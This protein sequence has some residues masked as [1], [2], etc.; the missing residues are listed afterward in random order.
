[1]KKSVW[2]GTAAT[3][4]SLLRSAVLLTFHDVLIGEHGGALGGG[5]AEVGEAHGGGQ[6]E[7]DGEPDQ[8]ARDEPPHA[9]AATAQCS[10]SHVWT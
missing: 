2:R 8:P 9:L 6:G 3:C 1:M 4:D 5:E 7:G 10:V